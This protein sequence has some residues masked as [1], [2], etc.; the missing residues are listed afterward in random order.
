[1]DLVATAVDALA[2]GG[3]DL[4]LFVGDLGI[5]LVGG[6]VSVG[7]EVLVLLD[8]LVFFLFGLG[9]NGLFLFLQGEAVL[10]GDL[11]IVGVDL[12]KGEKAVTVTAILDEGGLQAGFD[13]GDAGEVDIAAKLPLGGALEV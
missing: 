6:I 5:V 2:P 13:A 7:V 3:G 10:I 8:I 4:H 12:G 9:G 1:M 11:V